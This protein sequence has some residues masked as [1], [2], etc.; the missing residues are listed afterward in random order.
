[1]RARVWILRQ[2]P[3]S[4]WDN[5]SV[6]KIYET[7]VRPAIEF[8]SPIYHSLM[9]MGQ[10]A[11]VEAIQKM[12]L[13]VIYGWSFSY[14][15]LLEMSGIE[16]LED[17]RKRRVDS[18]AIKAENNP[19]ICELWFKKNDCRQDMRKFNKYK[20]QRTTKKKQKSNPV[21]HFTKQLNNIYIYR[22]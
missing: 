12:C 10:S 21:N 17:R 8:S 20:E 3:A 6:L 9:N 13:P 18:F 1:M 14:R 22:L 4:G 11:R 2:L 7:V 16:S 19:P 15:E 5:K